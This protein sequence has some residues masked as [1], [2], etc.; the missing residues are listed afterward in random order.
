MANKLFA[1][2]DLCPVR[3]DLHTCACRQMLEDGGNQ[4]WIHVACGVLATE[5]CQ[6]VQ[7]E[8]WHMP[9]AAHNAH[10]KQAYSAMQPTTA[11]RLAAHD[12]T[13]K[14]EG[15]SLQL[16]ASMHPLRKR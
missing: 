6:E 11:G 2:T 12:A 3:H 13:T 15:E 4:G 5:G 1:D 10:V 9:A 8:L 14:R 16:L 7:T